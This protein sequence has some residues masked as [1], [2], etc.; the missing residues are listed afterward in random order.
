[1]ERRTESKTFLKNKFDNCLKQNT[2]AFFQRGGSIELWIAR[3][4]EYILIENRTM[5]KQ[6]E[7][8]HLKGTVYLNCRA[9]C[10]SLARPCC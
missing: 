7:D 10:F 1:M 2:E 4:K 3:M 9:L 8:F 5:E 6:I